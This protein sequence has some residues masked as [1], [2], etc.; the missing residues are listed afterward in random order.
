[1]MLGHN[2]TMSPFILLAG[3]LSA[4]PIVA[5]NASVWVTPAMSAA[6][7]LADSTQR[8]PKNLLTL[9]EA[10]QW[11]QTGNYEECIALYRR[12]AAASPYA[13]LLDIG[14]TPAGRR[15]YLFVASRDKAFTPEAARRTG[16]PILL[17]QNGIHPGENGGKDASVMLLRDMLVT[18]HHAALLDKAIVLSIPVF[19]VDGHENISPYHRINEQ[20]PREMGFRGTAQRF[21]LNRD[22]MKAD[23]PEMRHWLRMFHQWQPDLLIDNHVTDGQDLQH[24]ITIA[25]EDGPNIHPAVG[26]WVKDVWVP[27]VWQNME[28]LGH[29]MGWY[30]AGPLRPGAPFL[31]EPSA[32]RYSTGYAAVRHRAAMLIETHSLKPFRVRAWDHYNVMVETLRVLADAGGALRAAVSAAER[33]QPTRIAVDF[34]PL[35]TGVPYKVRA[36]ETETYTGAASGG[37][38]LRYLPKAR[39]LDVTLIREAAV[40]AEVTVP[41]GYY[42]PRAWSAIA[43]L[44]VA[45]GVKVEPV[46]TPVTE[47]FEVTRFSNVSFPATP[48]ES[49]FQPNYTATMSREKHTVAAGAFFVSARQPLVKLI[50]N[51]LEPQAPDNVVKWGS[52]NSIFELKEYGADYIVEPLAAQLFA[53]NPGLKAEFE[54]ELARDPAFAKNPRARLQW[55]YRH[56]PFYERDKDFYPVLRLP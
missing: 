22:Y 31:D 15:M 25:V 38:V 30:V 4:E 23:A 42:I 53:A 36:L 41:R 9:A 11:Q 56:S 24:D 17:L 10:S 5:P 33:E 21:N 12:L 40:K 14:E 1:M 49:R 27:R 2:G 34:T 35:T 26:A 52:L 45:H 55:V 7:S 18:K 13:R 46:R 37:P 48:F 29:V 43:D 19:N 44:L 50:V 28:K 54:A 39:D 8:S 32:P 16:K 47:E 51:L 3:F 20:G 6:A